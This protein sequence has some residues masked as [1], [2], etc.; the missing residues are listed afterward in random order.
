M[1]IFKKFYF[2]LILLLTTAFTVFAQDLMNSEIRLIENN[3]FEKINTSFKNDLIVFV[4]FG[5]ACPIFRN[6]IPNL[7]TIITRF[8][9]KKVDFIILN[10]VKNSSLEELNEFRKRYHF[11]LP[12][13]ELKDFNLLREL[14]LSTLSQVILYSKKSGVL[15]SG[16]INNQ[17]TFDLARPSATEHYLSD[18]LTQALAGKKITKNRSRF[19]GCAITY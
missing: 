16:A 9:E 2:V 5:V 10:A 14:K 1:I 6:Q 3:K 17:F 8:N 4:A 7:Q 18:A 19:F 15:Y 11:N 12:V 13:Y